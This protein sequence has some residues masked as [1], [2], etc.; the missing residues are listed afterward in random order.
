MQAI[1]KAVK[2]LKTQEALATALGVKQSYI[3]RWINIYGQAPAK[4]IKRI[5]ALTNGEVTVEQLL[6]DHEK[7]SEKGS[8]RI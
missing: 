8:D 1:E 4:Y 3:S 7:K 6:A 2:K 5:S